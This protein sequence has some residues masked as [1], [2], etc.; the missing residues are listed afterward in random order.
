MARRTFSGTVISTTLASNISK[1]ATSITLVDGSTFPTGSVDKPF[2]VVV[3]RGNLNEEKIL[4]S[5]RSGNDL[6]VAQRGY[7]GTV[8]DPHTAGAIVDHV[9]DA[10]TI[11]SMNDII[12]DNE[13]MI[14]M[15]V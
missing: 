12:Y 11:Q 14:W 3:G 9:L 10:T 2:V 7:D 6:T 5:S 13:I 1:S 4:I 15:E 8:G